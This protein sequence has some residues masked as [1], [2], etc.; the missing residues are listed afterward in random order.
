MKYYQVK[1][2]FD[3]VAIYK[4]IQGN[5]FENTGRILVRN[6]LYTEHE[7]SKLMECHFSKRIKPELMFNIVDIP[8][9]KTYKFFG[10]RFEVK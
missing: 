1:E 3:N 7:Y 6:E 10:C 9:N 5:I 8:K 4:K 2:E